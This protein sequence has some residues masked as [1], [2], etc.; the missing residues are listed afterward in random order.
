MS[1]LAYN[2]VTDLTPHIEARE[3]RVAELQ[4]GYTRI[5]NGLLEAIMLAG[6]TQHQLLVFMAV[7]RKTYGFNKKS[8]WLSNEQLSQL[9]GILPHKCS[10]A[11]SALVKRKILSQNGRSVGINKALGEWES[12]DYL[13]KVNLPESGKDSLPE[14]GKSDYPNQVNTKDNITKDKKDNKN[15][16]PEQGQAKQKNTFDRHEKTDQSF[17]KVFWCAGMKKTG[18]QAAMKSFRTQFE[19]WRKV[20][21]GS[22]EEFARILAEDVRSRLGKQFGFENL[23]PA[24]Y[25]NGKRWEDE[26]P[27]QPVHQQAPSSPITVSKSG[28]VYFDR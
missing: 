16:L 28:Y 7:M 17:E 21:G 18:K 9:T 25:L 1:N 12:S 23:H 10:A 5:A 14:S 27:A 2:N 24:T 4:D 11:K 26:K 22:P 3:R 20:S 13:K 8:D 19:L 15:T 6:L